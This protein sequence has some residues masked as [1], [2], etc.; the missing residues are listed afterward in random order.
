LK[1]GTKLKLTWKPAAT[2]REIKS[3][4]IYYSS[5][6]NGAYSKVATVPEVNTFLEAPSRISSSDNTIYVSSTD[7]FPSNGV[8]EIAGL[9]TE[10]ASELV[11]CTGKTATSFT[12]C[13]RGV[14]GTIAAEHYNEAVVWKY[15]G[16]LG[17][18]MNYVSGY[19]KIKSVE[20]SGISSNLSNSIQM[21]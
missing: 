20:W 11:N 14:L 18:L 10:V 8:I 1:I 21:S 6:Q 4:E 9:S 15:T 12:G 17:H 5:T 3:Y 19:Y 2:H 7:G 13:T 16:S